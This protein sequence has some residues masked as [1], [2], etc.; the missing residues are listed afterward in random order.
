MML[1]VF[2]PG[3]R[4]W[5]GGGSCSIYDRGS[6]ILF[7]VMKIYILSIFLGQENLHILKKNTSFWVDM[8][9][10]ERKKYGDIVS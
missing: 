7:W 10:S 5:G 1:V 4:G 3:R 8:T 2:W 9:P 6:N